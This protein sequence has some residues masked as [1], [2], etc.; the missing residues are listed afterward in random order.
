MALLDEMRLMVRVSGSATD[1][2]IEALIADAKADMVRA[3]VAQPVV[4]GEMPMVKLAIACFVK[5]HFGLDASVEERAF[6]QESYRS[7]VVSLLNSEYNV[8]SM[9]GSDG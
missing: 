2:E 4:D 9:G 7:H 3:G 8:A 5:S 1:P 6:F